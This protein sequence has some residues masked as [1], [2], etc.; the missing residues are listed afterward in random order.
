METS[1]VPKIR[2]KNN[3][4][5][6][7]NLESICWPK[8]C[9]TCGGPPDHTEDVHFKKKFKNYGEIKVQVNGIPYCQVCASRI[10]ITK[11]IDAI[12]RV[13]AYVIGVPLGI[14]LVVLSAKSSSTKFIFLGL[15]FL[16]A[17]GIGYVLAYLLVRPPAKIILRKRMVEPVDAWMIEDD[18][19]SDGKKG[20]SVVIDIPNKTYADKFAVINGVS[21]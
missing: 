17:I 16:I 14:F 11:A 1:K 13:L 8:E 19:K 21:A 2:R 10:R 7:Q 20:L 9:C 4:I 6:E 5:V 18:E 12:V 15:I 3:F